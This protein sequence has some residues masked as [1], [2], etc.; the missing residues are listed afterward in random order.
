MSAGEA[1]LPGDSGGVLS[2]RLICSSR[3]SGDRRWS[4]SLCSC[5]DRGGGG[6]GAILVGEDEDAGR[7]S[8][9]GAG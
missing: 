2:T 9:A 1:C 7:I 3:P 4:T 5:D 6:G 8:G